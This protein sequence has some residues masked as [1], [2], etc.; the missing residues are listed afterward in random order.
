MSDILGRSSILITGLEGSGKSHFVMSQIKQILDM[1]DNEY[2]IFLANVDGVT[3]VDGQFHVVSPDFSWVDDAPKN[4]IVIYDEAGTIERF[5]NTKT[6]I[7]SHIDVETLTMRRHKNVLVVFVTQD[8]KLVHSGLRSLIKFHFHFSNPYSSGTETKCFVTA[9]VNDGFPKK[10]V[11]EEFDHKL[12]PSIFP[13]Y[14]SVDDGVKHDQKKTKHKKAQLMQRIAI[15]CFVLS[16]PI[17]IGMFFLIKKVK[18]NQFDTEAVNAKVNGTVVDKAKE[19][20]DKANPTTGMNTAGETN[21]Q[22][23]NQDASR[24]LELYKQQLPADYAVT[25]NNPDLRVSGMVMMNGVC[26]AYNGHGEFITIPDSQCVNYTVTAGAMQ[27]PN[28]NGQRITTQNGATTSNNESTIAEQNYNNGS[29]E[30]I[31]NPAPLPQNPT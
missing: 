14:K 19:F 6:K 8:A 24:S 22:Q 31:A 25:A 7:N 1:P 3:L 28:R 26:R 11:I 5:N 27:K 16:I 13:L 23:N 12:D 15:L 10:T 17:F 20:T 18:D 9:G 4:S 2:E 21:L 29:N 30:V